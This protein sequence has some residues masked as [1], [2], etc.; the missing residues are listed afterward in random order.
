MFESLLYVGILQAI[1]DEI[2]IG[3]YVPFLLSQGPPFPQNW[4]PFDP[5]SKYWM[6]VDVIL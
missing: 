2:K 1:L 6:Q 5:P 3:P 4:V